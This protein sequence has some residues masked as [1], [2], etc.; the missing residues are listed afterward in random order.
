MDNYSSNKRNTRT[1]INIAAGS[2]VVNTAS[3]VLVGKIFTFLMIGIALVLVTRLIGPTQYG[4]YTLA[5]AFAGIFGSIGYFGIGTALNKFISEYK[6]KKN[7]AEISVLFSNGIFLV[8]ISGITLTAICFE[9]SSFISGYVFHTTSMTYVIKV[10]SF[11]IIAAMLFGSVYDSML[12]LGSGRDIA[13]V[14][15]IQAFFQAGI[16]IVLA[17]MRYGALA[18]IYGLVLGSFIG[19]FAGLFIIFRRNGLVLC[20]PT[21][22]NMRKL[23]GFSIPVATANIFGSAV[24]SFGLQRNQ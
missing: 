20:M 24:G 15:G 2:K 18:P 10:V 19:F 23:L 1:Q 11:W 21:I 13:V 8:L 22:K 12:G 4:V 9:L 5:V 14:A 6:Q 3:Y 16:S 17:F 7:N